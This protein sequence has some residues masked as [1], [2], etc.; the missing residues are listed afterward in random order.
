M[1][2]T[3][4]LVGS[5]SVTS[6]P[7]I[8]TLPEVGLSNPDIERSIVVFPQPDEPSNVTNSFS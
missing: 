6:T 8:Y 1:V 4:L 7:S 3:C 5:K 2:L